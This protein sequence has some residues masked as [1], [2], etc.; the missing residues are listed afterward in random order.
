MNLTKA[1]KVALYF[2]GGYG[3]KEAIKNLMEL[4]CLT[5]NE[6]TEEELENLAR[7]LNC[8][9]TEEWYRRFYTE[10]RAELKCEFCPHEDSYDMR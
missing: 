4:S 8:H 6:K 3:R 7:Y 1:Q 10:I 2:F 9:K 5:T